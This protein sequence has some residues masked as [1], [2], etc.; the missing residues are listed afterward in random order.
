M[1]LITFCK[2]LEK[3]RVLPVRED[4]DIKTK[5]EVKIIGSLV[6]VAIAIFYIIFW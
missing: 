5:P 1:G 2:P 6:I 4:I 3:P